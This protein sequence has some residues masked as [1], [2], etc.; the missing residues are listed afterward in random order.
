MSSTDLTPGNPHGVGREGPTARTDVEP[1]RSPEE[2]DHAYP[3]GPPPVVERDSNYVSDEAL[4][5]WLAEKQDGLHGDLREHMDLART[6]SKLIEDLNRIKS[7]V[8]E[9]TDPDVVARE[10][11]WMLAAYKDTEFADGLREVFDSALEEVAMYSRAPHGS[12]VG[13]AQIDEASA[14]IQGHIDALG[15]DDQLALIQ[16]QSLTADIREASQL[17]SNLMASANQA[18]NTIVGNIRG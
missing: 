3:Y 16:I 2:S 14:L 4:L 7:L 11:S 13:E 8:D 1:A 12:V 9:G 5:L 18:A 17:A 6:R 15:R 10:M